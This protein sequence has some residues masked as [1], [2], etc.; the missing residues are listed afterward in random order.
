MS[1]LK[2]RVRKVLAVGS[3]LLGVALLCYVVGVNSHSAGKRTGYASGLETGNQQ[4]YEKAVSDV[5]RSEMK[6]LF[7][8]A[9]QMAE[10]QQN[11]TLRVIPQ[12]PDAKS[13]PPH[14]SKFYMDS[15]RERVSKAPNPQAKE[16]E[17]WAS[18]CVAQVELVGAPMT[19]WEGKRFETFTEYGREAGPYYMDLVLKHEVAFYSRNIVEFLDHVVASMKTTPC[20]VPAK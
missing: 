8:F 15:L 4:A 20:P 7:G 13:P 6:F 16:T 1:N 18:V 11:V 2:Q 12:G 3:I 19:V 5:G 17:Y 10:L 14:D 9:V